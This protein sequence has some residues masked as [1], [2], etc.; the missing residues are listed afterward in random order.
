[1][2]S[3]GYLGMRL[4]VAML[5][6]VAGLFAGLAGAQPAPGAKVLRP[7]ATGP[8]PEEA[9]Q[10]QLPPPAKP[11]ELRTPTQ[12]EME[13]ACNQNPK[14]RAKLEQAKQGKRPAKPLPAATEP[15]P[16]ERM[17]QSLPPP[18]QGLPP[19]GPRSSIPGQAERFFSWL[20]PFTPDQAW[21]QITGNATFTTVN[22]VGGIPAGII[23]LYGGVLSGSSNTYVMPNN[24][25]AASMS[26]ETKPYVHLYFYTGTGN[27]IIDFEASPSF[28]KLR[29]QPNG[30]I[31]DTWDY[32]TSGC[33]STVCHYVTVDYYE[34]G[35]HNW[36]F[37]AD[38]TASGV[39][40]Y[41]VT[42]KRYP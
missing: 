32:R 5:F 25:L 30:P 28:T 2:K 23:G 18:A 20:N 38:P 15:S 42:I 39:N 36:Y 7:A 19:M 6:C 37:W 11:E 41:S 14:C 8:S 12:A 29:H 33:G 4:M 9:L 1:M 31:L 35:W 27:Y 10:R 26:T 3:R 40:F 24:H 17:Q 16:E 21:A 34:A 13:N 22:R